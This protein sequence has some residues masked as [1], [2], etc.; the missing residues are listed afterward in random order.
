MQRLKIYPSPT[1]SP[2]FGGLTPEALNTYGERAGGPVSV[3]V[4]DSPS[5]VESQPSDR[6]ELVVVLSGVHE[7]ETGDETRRLFAGDIIVIDGPTGGTYGIRRIGKE[8]A[9]VMRFSLGAAA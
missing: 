9:V 1:G 8:N 4:L 5:E 6:S 3:D 7:F 2:A